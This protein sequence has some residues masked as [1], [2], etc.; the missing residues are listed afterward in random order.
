[1]L[2]YEGKRIL[3]G[4]DS[5]NLRIQPFLWPNFEN[6][7][8]IDPYNRISGFTNR[9]VIPSP[10]FIFSYKDHHYLHISGEYINLDVPIIDSITNALHTLFNKGALR[11]F[12]YRTKMTYYDYSLDFI[13]D[14]LRHLVKGISGMEFC[15]DFKERHVRIKDD[16]RIIDTNAPTFPKFLEKKLGDRPPCLVRKD[17]TYY[18]NDFNLNRKSTLK[19][20]DR[21]IWLRKKNNELS[22][23]TIEDNP[24]N[25]R[26]EFVLQNTKNSCLAISNLEGNYHQVINKFTPY[27]AKIYKKYFLRNVSVDIRDHPYFTRIYHLAHSDYIRTY[28]SLETIATDKKLNS[29]D[30]DSQK[31]YRLLDYLKKEARREAKAIKEIPIEYFAFSSNNMTTHNSYSPYDY[32][33]ENKILFE[34]EDEGN[35]YV[36]FK[37]RY[38]SPTFKTIEDEG[39]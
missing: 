34:L 35:K 24:Y 7:K 4:I 12:D 21:A 26:I 39:T 32:A 33:E 16:A 23:S 3:E 1:M 22:K 37:D 6:M 9:S 25:K 2:F 19:L 27:L 18:S 13:R 30:S 11:L 17:T 15:F 8:R 10:D 20:Y 38:F 5:I 14:N 28:K 36:F 29:K 31:E